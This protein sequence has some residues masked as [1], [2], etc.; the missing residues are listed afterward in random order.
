V[1]LFKLKGDAA[2]D[3]ALANIK[4]HVYATGL[5]NAKSM[6]VVE[7]KGPTIVYVGFATTDDKFINASNVYYVIDANSDGSPDSFGRVFAKDGQIRNPSG[8][9]VNGGDSFVAGTGDNATGVVWWLQ[10][11]GDRAREGQVRMQHTLLQQ[12]AVWCF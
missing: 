7:W 8:V 12:V 1:D 10:G 4:V 6:A 2:T 3:H 9:A 11:M 5:A